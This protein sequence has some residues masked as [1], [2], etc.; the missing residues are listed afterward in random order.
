MNGAGWK[1][2]ISSTHG[3]VH[4]RDMDPPA[5]DPEPDGSASIAGNVLHRA[6]AF[7]GGLMAYGEDVREVRH[8]LVVYLDK[9][10]KGS[11]PAELPIEQPSPRRLEGIPERLIEAARTGDQERGRQDESLTTIGN[12]SWRCSG[13]SG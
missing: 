10:L 12:T 2:K 8:R 9:I 7:D 4:A 6:D 11:K 5:S 13:S 1:A 3:A